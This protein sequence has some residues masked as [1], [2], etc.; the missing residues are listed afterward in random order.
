MAAGM[1]SKLASRFAV[2]TATLAVV[3]L[4]ASSCGAFPRSHT[5]TDA[6]QPAGS[7]EI[8]GWDGTG[9]RLLMSSLLTLTDGSPAVDAST[10][11]FTGS[12]WA[13]V[14]GALA[15][16]SFNAVNSALVYDIGR[17]RDVLAAGALSAGSGLTPQGTWEF[18]GQAWN[19]VSTPHQLPFLGQAV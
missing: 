11:S 16:P 19:A 7:P 2:S 12:E 10:W 14:S 15:I 3:V 4:L 8:L 1:R 18:D 6:A 17:H 9:G 5:S 13:P